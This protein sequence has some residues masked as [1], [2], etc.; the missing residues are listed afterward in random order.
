MPLVGGGGSGAPTAA[1]VYPM[2]ATTTAAATA[3]PQHGGFVSPRYQR[4]VLPPGTA[5]KIG[6]PAVF[7][8]PL[9]PPP[10]APPPRLQMTTAPQVGGWPGHPAHICHR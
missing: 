6:T 9:H 10:A 2:T 7:G 8:H 4:A 1:V 3:Y 5:A